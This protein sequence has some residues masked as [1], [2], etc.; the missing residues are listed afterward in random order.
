MIRTPARLACAMKTKPPPDSAVTVV[1]QDSRGTGVTRR[2][3]SAQQTLALAT[4]C[5]WT[6]SM[7]LN[8]FVRAASQATS[9]NKVMSSNCSGLIHLDYFADPNNTCQNGGTPNYMTLTCDCPETYYG[10]TCSGSTIGDSKNEIQTFAATADDNSASMSA[11]WVVLAILLTAS[12]VV[13]VVV[14]RRHKSETADISTLKKLSFDW[15]EIDESHTK[16]SLV[17]IAVEMA[18]E[19]QVLELREIQQTNQSASLEMQMS[20]IQQKLNIFSAGITLCELEFE[21]IPSEKVGATYNDALE[22]KHKNRY[23][24]VLP[25]KSMSSTA[26]LMQN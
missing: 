2:S 9:A 15:E 23:K 22:N 10:E 25:C 20:Y 16:E 7:I 8:V 18:M 5:A 6:K 3:M 12:A 21:E 19:G 4:Q 14:V 26:D 17:P 1:E 11:V 13:F 24:N